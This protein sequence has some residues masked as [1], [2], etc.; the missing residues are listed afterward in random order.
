MCAISLKSEDLGKNE[1]MIFLFTL[2]REQRKG[3]N[4]PALNLEGETLPVGLR[5]HH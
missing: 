3:G 1:E 4:Y 5:F 2:Y